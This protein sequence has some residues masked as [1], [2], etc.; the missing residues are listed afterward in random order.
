M[1]TTVDQLA[2]DV[3]FTLRGGGR[4][5]FMRYADDGRAVTC[6]GPIN[7]ARAR[8]RTFPLDRIRTIHRSRE[9]HP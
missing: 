9:Q 3:E 8:C 2:P 1:T 7:T 4:Y 6:W 5:R